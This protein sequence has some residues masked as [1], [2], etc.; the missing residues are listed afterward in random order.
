MKIK[1]FVDN[2]MRRVLRQ[3]REDQGPDA[4]ILSNRRVD[5]GIEVIA[6]VDYDQALMQQALQ[7][8]ATEAQ[9]E[10]QAVNAV[11]DL[12]WP[13]QE[14]AVPTA[15]D[16][17]EIK[18]LAA[19]IQQASELTDRRAPKTNEMDGIDDDRLVSLD[20]LRSEITSM[21]GM[22]ESQLSSMN[23]ER[24]A[25]RNPLRAQVL[26]NLTK[27]GIAP[28]ICNIIVDRI[29]PLKEPRQLWRKPLHMLAKE[30]PVVESNLLKDGGV[31][32]L[33]GPTGVGKT[34]T[35]AKLATRY[36]MQ[37]G[38]GGI[39]LISADAHRI[40][41]QEQLNTLANILG[42]KVHQVDD[43]ARLEETLQGVRDKKLVLIDTEGSSQ[44]DRNLAERLAAYGNNE[45]RVH[46]YLTLAATCQEAGLDET[47][48]VFNKVPLSGA[49]VTKIDEAAQLG[50]VLSTLIRHGLKAAFLCDGQ[51]VPDDLHFAAKKRLWLVN[52][53]IECMR[54][55]SPTVDDDTM[56]K[57]FGYAGA[58]NA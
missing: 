55:S 14:S 40:G 1:R 39:A 28:D 57:R 12:D 48:R 13:D 21:R 38:A 8:P 49:I 32:A 17:Q 18:V 46:Y 45:E 53:S 43:L 37:H 54:A 41:A 44:R 34:T 4:V 52:Q 42:V 5:D 30:I 2:N 19:D 31:T 29:G 11:V 16:G 9:P 3:V 24:Q 56:I 36:A 15:D 35:I 26:R 25:T 51:R 58:L 6:A 20:A 27:I 7:I 50:C 22:L 33:I 23:W 10:L 47:I